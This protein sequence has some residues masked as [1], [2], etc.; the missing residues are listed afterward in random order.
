[1]AFLDNSGDIILDAVLTEVGRRKMA[2]GTFKISKF[3]LSDDEIN[4]G[5][6]RLN[7][8]SGSAYRGLEILQTPILE[9]TTELNLSTG[10]LSLSNLNIL[11]MPDL[12]QNTKLST[13]L[14]QKNNTNYVAVNSE[15]QKAIVAGFGDG[16]S[17]LAGQSSTERSIVLESGI[18]NSDVSMTSTNQASYITS[19]NMLDTNVSVTFNTNYIGYVLGTTPSARFA[20]SED[21]SWIGGS[22]TL[23]RRTGVAPADRTGFGTVDNPMSKASIYTP[24]TADTD[25]TTLIN[26]AG[27]I[28]SMAAINVAVDP[29]L[30][31]TTSQP[32]DARWTKFGTTGQ[33]ITDLAGTY[34]TI[35]TS[36]ELATNNSSA[37]LNI[38]ITLIKQDTA[39]RQ[40]HKKF[41]EYEW[42]LKTLKPLILAQM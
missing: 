26:C 36:L 16:Y 33:T 7:H 17:M 40:H 21:G 2:D 24:T 22:P 38:P 20:T 25:I 1:M 13:A 10:L 6:Y 28:G 39:Q 12:L 29:A 18:N 14:K 5:L 37:T 35:A 31:T 23:R 19:T 42:Q 4:Y 27:I 30:T 9:G 11:Y 41:G 3:A 34:S 8:S 32:S 15:T